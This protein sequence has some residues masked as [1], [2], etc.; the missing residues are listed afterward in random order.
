MR[1]S[2][3]TFRDIWRMTEAEWKARCSFVKPALVKWREN[4][5]RGK[6]RRRGEQM[7]AERLARMAAQWR[8]KKRPDIA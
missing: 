8:S 3:L 6:L 4:G 5:R 1:A 2:P 7:T